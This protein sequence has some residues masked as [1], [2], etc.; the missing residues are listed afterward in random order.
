MIGIF[1]IG[2]TDGEF[3]FVAQPVGHAA[4][5]QSVGIQNDFGGIV[6]R[7][8]V[9]RRRAFNPPSFEIEIEV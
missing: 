8:D 1:G 2:L 7:L 6:G 4:D 9:Q 3:E 5:H